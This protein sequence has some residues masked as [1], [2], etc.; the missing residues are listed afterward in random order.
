MID[1]T[2]DLVVIGA[3]PGGYVAAIRAA[4]LGRRVAIVEREE[5]GGICLNWG[6]I[7]TKALLHTAST[8]A[9]LKR[10]GSLG[11][12]VPDGMRVDLP[13]VVARSREIAAKLRDGVGSLLRKNRVQVYRGVGRILNPRQVAV[14]PAAQGGVGDAARQSPAAQG[15]DPVVLTAANVIIATG[16]SPREIDGFRVDGRRIW[17]YRHALV[18]E[19]IP[20]TLLVVGAG[21]IGMEFASFYAALGSG[22]SVIEAR[23]RVLPN[24]DQEL[25]EH[26][27]T[28]FAARGI[29]VHCSATLVS[30]YPREAGVQVTIQ[31]PTEGLDETFERVLVCA[32]VEG[33]VSGLGLEVTR[34]ATTAAGCIVVDRRGETGEP[35]IYAIGDVS[36][37]PM[38]AHK[39]SHEAIACV[40][41]LFGARASLPDGMSLES[42]PG[43]DP[44]S[45]DI[46]ACTYCDPQVASIGLTEARAREVRRTIRVGRFPFRANGK[47]LAMGEGDG[48]VKLIFDAATGEVLG[49]HMVGPEVTELIHGMALAK[50]LEATEEDLMRTVFPHPTLSEAVGEAAMAAFGRAIHV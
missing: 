9:Q 13:R 22:V 35:G 50:G 6:C 7:P 5:L 24:E 30:A 1:A 32:G 41:H 3:G 10:A 18:P 31:T 37:G 28:A 14:T 26:V 20:G 23:D 25:S 16:A 21:A 15:G 8:L 38:L 19:A 45:T 47:A 2:F 40:E 17:N 43:A 27:R 29:L 33:N 11:I 48:F 12:V 46:A 36:G 4:Q 39:A 49:A 34:V 44:G 42:L